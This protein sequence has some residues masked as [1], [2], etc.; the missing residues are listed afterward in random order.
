M[1]LMRRVVGGEYFPK[2]CEQV[3]LKRI[4]CFAG[5][6]YIPTQPK[7]DCIV[8]IWGQIAQCILPR[9]F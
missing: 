2:E 5:D 7:F 3:R 8:R 4:I 9:M 1:F 6:N